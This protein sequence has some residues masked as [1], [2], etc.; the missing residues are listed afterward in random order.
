MK[1][2][3][4][5]TPLLIL[6]FF[7]VLFQ[8]A[9]FLWQMITSLKLDK[10]LSSLPPILPNEVTWLHYQNLFQN[11]NFI[12]YIVNSSVIAVGV[13]IICLFL[14][15]LAA[16]SLA[17]LP[18][19]GKGLILV[20]FL[21]TS[22]FPQIAVITPLY[23]LIKSLGLYNTHMGLIFSYML[24]G[25]PLSVLLLYGFFRNIPYEIEEAA[26]MDGC[27][28]F[29]TYWQVCLPL[30]APGLVTAGLLVFISSWNEF[31]FAITF[32]NSV[33]AQTIPVGIAM[34]PQMYFVPWG[35]TAATSIL[36]TLPL[37]LLVLIF[38]KKLTKGIMGGAVKG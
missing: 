15:S 2:T 11:T 13:T 12:K 29:R 14:G 6:A 31:L 20:L 21:S 30:M 32:T 9:P 38:E 19:K 5:K 8:L 23:N 27:G 26:Y 4:K 28:Y 7:I 33:D 17:R 24:F 10:D 34:M 36:V 3:I 18:I 25:L 35:D 1:E 16:Y 22:M 37:I